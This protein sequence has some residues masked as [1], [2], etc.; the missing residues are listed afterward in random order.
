MMREY[1]VIVVGGGLAGLIAA[2][3]AAGRNKKV[4]MLT[5]GAGTLAIGGGSVDLLG[6]VGEGRPLASP[7][8]GL[9]ELPDTHPYSKIGRAGIQA[10]LDY[11]KTVCRQEGYE[12][13][14]SPEKNYWVPTAAGTLKPTCLIPKTM[15]TAPLKAAEK[16]FVAGFHRLKD[17]YPQIV[18][19]GLA[20]IPVYAKKE[21]SVVWLDTGMHEGRDITALE[22]ARW[23]DTEAGRRSCA[24]QLKKALP[25]GAVV[26]VP[27]VLGTKPSYA[28][29][30]ELEKTGGYRLVE[31][32]GLPPAIIGLRLRNLWLNF[33]KKSGVTVVEN[34]AVTGS[35]VENGRCIAIKTGNLDRERTYRAQS[36][37][38]TTG[39]FFGGGLGSQPGRATEAVF[40]LP[41]A[42]PA[43]PE[44]WGA[45]QLFGTRQPFAQIG[46]VADGRMAPVDAA[47][48]P[49]L[50][51]VF[52]AGRNLAGYDFSFEKSGNGVAIVTGYQASLSV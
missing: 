44:E 9:T 3:G 6:Y 30:E 36:F 13:I 15:D 20:K 26:I 37:V 10:A 2:A 14:G 31:S 22:V 29:A 28:V 27:P 25:P 17:Y 8:Q 5:K 38:L 23:L 52:V 19:Q 43:N 32:T 1:D 39:G 50:S 7:E 35:V 12:Y 16:I 18:V 21:F 40:D 51:N 42:A 4:L 48:Q 46:I 41:V 33:A 24:E 47:G 11:F 45:P 34:A 49:I